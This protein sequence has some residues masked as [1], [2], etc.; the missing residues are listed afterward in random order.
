M[1][2]STGIAIILASYVFLVIGSGLA[3]ELSITYRQNKK[4][5]K[6]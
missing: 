3:R 6:N 2:K 4:G 1:D 5:M